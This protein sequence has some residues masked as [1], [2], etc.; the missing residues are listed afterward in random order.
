MCRRVLQ[1]DSAGAVCEQLRLHWSFAGQSALTSIRRPL[2]TYQSQRCVAL[3]PCSAPAVLLVPLTC[4]THAYDRHCALIQTFSL[5]AAA[6]YIFSVFLHV[7]ALP[8][9]HGRPRI[10]QVAPTTEEQ[11]SNKGCSSSGT[12]QCSVGYSSQTILLQQQPCEFW[13]RCRTADSNR[14]TQCQRHQHFGPAS[15]GGVALLHLPM[16]AAACR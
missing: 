14:R 5:T 13:A 2:P 9:C 16:V 6:P 1:N 7:P 4:V 8:P 3:M 10:P 11:R 15:M 12:E